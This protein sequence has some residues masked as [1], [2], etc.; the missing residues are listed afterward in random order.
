MEVDQLVDRIVW[1][2]EAA[3]SSLAFHTLAKLAQLVEQRT[4][5][6]QVISS[7]LILGS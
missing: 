3:S 1:D 6:A 2:D 7:N 4:C 5:N